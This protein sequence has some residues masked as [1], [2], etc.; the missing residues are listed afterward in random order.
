MI[1][2]SAESVAPTTTEIDPAALEEAAP[3]PITI[4]PVSPLLDSPLLSVSA[5]DG[6]DGVEADM[7]RIAPDVP[8]D[9]VPDT[10]LTSPVD[11]L[12]AS[13]VAITMD[14]LSPSDCVD[15]V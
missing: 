6:P 2:P 14:P 10:T 1:P 13:P 4:D 3:T 9:D 8:L 15:E 11:A 12:S 7:M 5:P